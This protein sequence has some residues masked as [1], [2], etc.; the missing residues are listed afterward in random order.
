MYGYSLSL[1]IYNSSF[2]YKNIK[3]HEKLKISC[4]K[5][6]KMTLYLKITLLMCNISYIDTA[7]MFFLIY[8]FSASIDVSLRGNEKNI[9]N[10]HGDSLLFLI[11]TVLLHNAF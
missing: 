9:D 2:R 11:I 3:L 10:F 6:M 5:S 4:A 8:R 7:G 1:F